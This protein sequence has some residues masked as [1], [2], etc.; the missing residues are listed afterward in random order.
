MINDIENG[1][2][3]ENKNIKVISMKKGKDYIE[4]NVDGP[5]KKEVIDYLVDSI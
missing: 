5:S 3:P 4:V 2:F 1:I